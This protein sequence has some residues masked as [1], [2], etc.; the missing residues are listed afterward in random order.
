M[1]R[2]APPKPPR[3][4][5]T[6]SI[7]TPREIHAQNVKDLYPPNTTSSVHPSSM[8]PSSSSHSPPPIPPF[9]PNGKPAIPT[10]IAAANIIKA[11]KRAQSTDDSLR[12]NDPQEDNHNEFSNRKSYTENSYIII[13]EDLSS[14]TARPVSSMFGH[15]SMSEHKSHSPSLSSI[16]DTQ[17]VPLL[18][19]SSL[20]P[21]K[22]PRLPSHREEEEEEEEGEG[23]GEDNIRKCPVS[24]QKSLPALPSGQTTPTTKIPILPPGKST[25]K[26][27][28]KRPD[29]PP[30]N[31]SRTKS[32]DSSFT[33]TTSNSKP[34]PLPPQKSYKNIKISPE[35]SPKP[36]LNGINTNLQDDV[37]EHLSNHH[38]STQIPV[39][40]SSVSSGVPEDEGEVFS[41]DSRQ[42]TPSCITFSESIFNEGLENR[43]EASND[44]TDGGQPLQQT[45]KQPRPPNPPR[46]GQ[47]QPKLKLK[48]DDSWIQKRQLSPP[49]SPNQPLISSTPPISSQPY[50]S[51]RILNVPENQQG[52]DILANKSKAMIGSSGLY[53]HPTVRS[54]TPEP[55]NNV[56]R[57]DSS[58][59]AT[60]EKDEVS[61]LQVPHRFKKTRRSNSFHG[62]SGHKVRPT[63]MIEDV[64]SLIHPSIHL[65]IHSFIYP[66]I[67]S[68]IKS[69][70]YLFSF[71]T[72]KIRRT[73]N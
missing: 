19:K 43:L 28:P 20:N 57:D 56:E 47:N 73:M 34:L 51:H 12:D 6:K 25:F 54:I 8:S 39:S 1:S 30:K 37:I 58:E 4:R 13:E 29:P 2:P 14:R 69:F 15:T 66:S 50:R 16:E 65:S 49:A 32:E 52:H 46:F 22:I 9:K 7:D 5:K 40:P 38:E 36:V 59:D 33:Q 17:K 11:L 72:T 24:T 35:E 18:P 3:L 31:L 26:T 41:C 21:S 10:S 68:S 70:F 71:V 45:N 62:T 53:Y 63:S 61:G 55:L 44:E 23:E 27:F 48:G 42:T 64:V 60:E 67:H